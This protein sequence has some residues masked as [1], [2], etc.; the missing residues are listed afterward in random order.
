MRI[1][2][3]FGHPAQF[4]FLKETCN[5]GHYLFSLIRLFMNVLY[6]GKMMIINIFILL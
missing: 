4:L 3:Y 5:L 2:V 1:M 6:E